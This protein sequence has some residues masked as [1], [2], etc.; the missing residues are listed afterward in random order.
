MSVKNFFTYVFLI[1][2]FFVFGVSSSQVFA[3]SGTG[4][5]TSTDPYVITTCTEL[6]SIDDDAVAGTTEDVFYQLANDIDCSDTVNW[7]GGLGFDPIGLQFSEFQ[8]IF[9]G[10]NF[11]I[12]DLYINRPLEQYVGLFSAASSNAIL[13][14]ITLNNVDITGL[15]NVGGLAGYSRAVTIGV[16]IN[17]SV[18]GT[19][20]IGGFFGQLQNTD[21]ASNR[22][23]FV[24]TISALGDDVGGIVGD[25]S[26]GRVQNAFVDATITGGNFVGGLVGRFGACCGLLSNSYA[27]GS[28]TGDTN[29]GGAIG[30]IDD[31]GQIVIENIFA[32]V[33]ITGNNALGAVIGAISNNYSTITVANIH[34]DQTA[35]LTA[36]CFSVSSVT[37]DC[38]AQN[39]DGLTPEYF[40]DDINEPLASWDF[41]DVWGTQGGDYPILE[42][43]DPL[44]LPGTVQNLSATEGGSPIEVVITWEAPESL[45]TFPLRFYTIEIKEADNAWTQLENSDATSDIVMTFND[46]LPSTEYTIRVQAETLYGVSDWVETIYTTPDADSYTISSCAEL[47]NMSQIG[48]SVDSYTLTTDIDCSDIPN[49][50]PISWEGDP[51]R[52]VLDG[53]GYTISNITIEGDDNY[54][55]GL[56]TYMLNAT[57]QNVILRDGSINVINDSGDCGALAGGTNNVTISGVRIQDY[58]IS[59]ADNVGGLFGNIQIFEGDSSTLTNVGVIGG[60]ISATG[61]AGGMVGYLDIYDGAILIMEE[62]FTDTVV[63]SEFDSTG[64]FFGNLYLEND[65]NNPSVSSLIMRNAY[66]KSDLSVIDADNAGGIAGNVELNSDDQDAVTKIT[67]ENVYTL[68]DI[69][70]NS[71]VGGFFGD[72]SS[73]DAGEEIEIINSFTQA[74][75]TSGNALET[76]AIVGEDNFINGEVFI[77]DGVYFDQTATG[78]S[79]AIYEEDYEGSFAIN[80]DGSQGEYF[81]GNSTNSPLDEWD[82]ATVWLIVEGETPVLR[83]TVLAPSDPEP[84]PNPEPRRRT[85]SGGRASAA[86][87]AQMG[88]TLSP[89]SPSNNS[90][91]QVLMQQ[92]QQL[93][94]LVLELQDQGVPVSQTSV[95]DSCRTTVLRQGSRGECVRVLQQLLNVTPTSGIFGP[96]TFEAVKQFQTEHNLNS[97]G[98]VGSLTWGKL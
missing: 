17:G 70:A 23:S 83:A 64:G 95:P 29:V 42:P 97:D 82:F 47:Q 53:Q 71:E 87:L 30:A 10:N 32:A 76:H 65:D 86:T 75:L 58:L 4:S 35:A 44:A 18:D 12:N 9:D 52:G 79:Q 25:G 91:I 40:Y 73:L 78:Q 88:I 48:A 11:A 15:H 72:I 8:G 67:L 34:F 54:G 1:I 61:D 84:E 69:S 38:T 81:F 89:S 43:N 77:L 3:F 92:L 63:S 55:F 80:T 45:G 16:A 24:G 28:V 14:N 31:A 6:Q 57:I 68:G 33:A 7:N 60:Q 59:C 26:N 46:L 36:S 94:A 41:V 96:L 51:F 19:N 21:I 37:V 27:V 49:F 22:L 74:S 98:I 62:V 66:S 90:Q 39:T 93:Q 50:E 13:A 2:G 56:F 20:N 5:G 85:T